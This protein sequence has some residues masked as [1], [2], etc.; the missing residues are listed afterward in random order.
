MDYMICRYGYRKPKDKRVYCKKD[1]ALC[2]HVYM[3]QLNCRW[4]QTAQ[5]AEC[6]KAVEEKPKRSKKK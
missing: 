4:Q 5:A 1:D 3:C 2:V 6:P